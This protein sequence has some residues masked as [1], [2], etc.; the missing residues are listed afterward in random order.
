MLSIK[1]LDISE[2]VITI[3]AELTK[4]RKSRCVY[5]SVKTRKILQRWLSYKDRY[6]IQTTYFLS[7]RA[8]FPSNFD[9]LNPISDVI[10]KEPV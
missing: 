5:F 10:L 2:R 3:P 7:K 1:Y 4:G 8:D 9:H 6:I